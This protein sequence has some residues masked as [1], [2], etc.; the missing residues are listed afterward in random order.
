[1]A[2]PIVRSL[3]VQSDDNRPP[4][5]AKWRHRCA[6]HLSCCSRACRSRYPLAD[7]MG[8][9]DS[10]GTKHQKVHKVGLISVRGDDDSSFAIESYARYLCSAAILCRSSV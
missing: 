6:A 3:A 7:I 2:S 1:M 5:A 10:L 4:Q 9:A 8:M